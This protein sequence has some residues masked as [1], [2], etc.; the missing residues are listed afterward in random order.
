MILEYVVVKNNTTAADALVTLRQQ[1]LKVK[2]IRSVFVVD[3]EERLVG[4]LSIVRLALTQPK[5]MV[6]DIMAPDIIFVTG[7]TNQEEC[8]R[9]MERYNLDQLPVVDE[10]RR[11]RWCHHERGCNRYSRGR[12]HRGYV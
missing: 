4:E 10:D 6:K 1:E 12:S 3:A 11:A 7:E 2:D 9:V 8:A 5:T